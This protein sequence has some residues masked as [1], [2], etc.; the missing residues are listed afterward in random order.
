MAVRIRLRR[1]G[2]KKQPQYRLVAAEA[3]HPRDGR[4][5]EV[6]GHYNPR[7]DP[8]AVTVN[9][10]RAL[11]WLQHGAQPTDT[12]KSLLVRT[13]VW[14]QFTGEPTPAPRVPAPRV[15]EAPVEAPVEV[16]AEVS[17]EAAP[18]VAEDAAVEA[19]VE[20][21]EEAA[22][23]AAEEA[24]PEAAEEAAAET[25]PEAEGEDKETQQG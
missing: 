13:G 20:A 16:P 4:F 6:L 7:V 2:K 14:E 19:P 22:P 8:A 25:V 10:E 12:A 24:A 1:I 21:T 15:P 23:E 17:V 9:G 3:A 11:Y 5:I 18:E